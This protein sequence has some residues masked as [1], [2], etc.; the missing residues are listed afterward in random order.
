[1]RFENRIII[2]IEH[3]MPHRYT[4]QDVYFGN[5]RKLNRSLSVLCI[6]SR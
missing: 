2:N 1:M 6:E 3:D 5:I 4:F